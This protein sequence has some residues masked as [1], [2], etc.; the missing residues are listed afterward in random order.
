MRFLEDDHRQRSQRITEETESKKKN[1]NAALF[2][3]TQRS[4]RITV[5]TEVE[6]RAEECSVCKFIIHNIKIL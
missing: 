1:I 4:Q 3:T 6:D 2:T 5:E